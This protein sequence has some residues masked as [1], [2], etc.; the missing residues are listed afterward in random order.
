MLLQFTLGIIV[1][2]ALGVGLFFAIRFLKRR[3]LMGSF[4]QSLF[5]I[6]VPKQLAAEGRDFKIEINT[7]EQLLSSLVAL[8]SPFTLEVVVP[9]VGEEIHFFIAVP[10][11]MSEVAMKQVQGLWNG[12][13]VEPAGDDYNIFNP[14][15]ASVAAY[16]LQ[17]ENYALPV[18]TY[19]EIGADTFASI[20]GA[21]AKINEIGEGAALQI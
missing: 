15:G 8:K 2:A 1:G 6:K 17:K 11:A 7:T 10:K 13:S 20:V 5:M 4:G 14:A 18:R 3:A 16:V 21:F 19:A 12:A 9:H